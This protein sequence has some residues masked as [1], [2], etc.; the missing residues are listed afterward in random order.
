MTILFLHF[1][2]K[3]RK[4]NCPPLNPLFCVYVEM[5]FGKAEQLP[6]CWHPFCFVLR[7]LTCG[8]SVCAGSLLLA[9]FEDCCGLWLDRYTIHVTEVFK[10]KRAKLTFG[11]FSIVILVIVHLFFHCSINIQLPFCLIL[12]HM[13]FY[14]PLASFYISIFLK[15]P[16]CFVFCCFFATI[17]CDSQTPFF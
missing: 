1:I 5:L 2:V 8:R 13:A 6:L 16:I 3:L 12:T 10:K 15:R 17:C 14:T 7:C 11:V 9:C 4:T